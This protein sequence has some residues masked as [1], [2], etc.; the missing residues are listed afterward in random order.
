M[1]K[2]NDE[3][4]RPTK[5][6]NHFYVSNK[7]FGLDCEMFHTI[8]RELT[9]CEINLQMPDYQQEHSLLEGTTF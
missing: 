1:K 4:P 6:W 7:E 5:S 8:L 2:N 9:Q 3:G